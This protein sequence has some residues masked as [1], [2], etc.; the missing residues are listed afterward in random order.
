MND[1][2][3]SVLLGVEINTTTLESNL[4]FPYI[5]MIFLLSCKI[6]HG[7]PDVQ[8]FHPEKLLSMYLGGRH[9]NGHSST[10]HDIETLKTAHSKWIN[11]AL[12]TRWIII[13]Q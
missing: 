9:E 5:V 13:Q 3:C 1:N 6:E 12:L 10:A 8:P 7:C 11:C 4:T 2:A